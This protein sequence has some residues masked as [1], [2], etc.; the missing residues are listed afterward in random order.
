M[1][2]VDASP[3]QTLTYAGDDGTRKSVVIDGPEG[4]V[5]LPG[6]AGAPT[7][8]AY[9]PALSTYTHSANDP[10]PEFEQP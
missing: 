5:V 3:G 6:A 2:Y 7:E 4:I 1:G 8:Y 9:Q 10:R